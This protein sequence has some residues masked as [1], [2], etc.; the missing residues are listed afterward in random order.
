MG[1]RNGAY[2]TIWEVKQEEGKNYTTVSLSISR[3]DK[4]TDE[5]VRDFS[6]SFVRFIGTAHERA[7]SLQPKDRIKLGDVDVSNSYNKEEKKEYITY[8]VFSFESPDGSGS[9][10]HSAPAG[11]N[12]DSDDDDPF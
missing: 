3:K 1:F 12:D 8:K 7:G 11:T 5:Y 10:A 9:G 2:A 6:H 4:R